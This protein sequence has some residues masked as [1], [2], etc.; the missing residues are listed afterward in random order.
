M[1]RSNSE[2]CRG[3]RRGKEEGIT[4]SGL[5]QIPIEFEMWSE[6]FPLVFFGFIWEYTPILVS[7]V[8][9][10]NC[11]QTHTHARTHTMYT[12]TH[13]V[14]GWFERLLIGWTAFY[15]LFCFAL[16]PFSYSQCSQLHSVMFTLSFECS[17]Q[18]MRSTQSVYYVN[19]EQITSTS[20]SK[21]VR[22]VI[23][24]VNNGKG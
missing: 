5:W 16:F 9:S 12:H 15:S 20:S 3:Q 8:R 10:H 18:A 14:R 2:L 11:I 7:K 21:G 19:T 6:P 1:G 22:A 24:R 4:L 17:I 23:T 13:A